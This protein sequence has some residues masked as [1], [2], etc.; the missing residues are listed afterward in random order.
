MS[1]T[2]SP[3]STRCY[4]V[5][6]VARVWTVSRASVYR[7]LKETPLSSDA[8]CNTRGRFGIGRIETSG[9]V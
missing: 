7:S 1:Q 8:R 4:G 6:H 3:S 9:S 5:A 2:L